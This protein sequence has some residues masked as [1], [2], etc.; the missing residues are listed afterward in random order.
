VLD[1][2]RGEGLPD[3]RQLFKLCGRSRVDV[4]ERCIAGFSL[5]G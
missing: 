3:A 5:G 4:Y 2:A 1:D